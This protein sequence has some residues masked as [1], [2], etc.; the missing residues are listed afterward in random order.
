MFY[1]HFGLA[2]RSLKRNVL[3][4]SLMVAAIGVGIGASMTTLTLFRAMSADPIPDKSSRL[5]T[6]QID[7]WGK[8]K[9]QTAPDEPDK[10]PTQLTYTDAVGLM[11]AHPAFRQTAMYAIDLGLAPS[12]PRLQSFQVHARAVYRDFFA[13]FDVPF[14][15]GVAWPA[16]DDSAHSQVVVITRALNDRLFAGTNS[17]GQ[18][19]RL[20]NQSYRVVGVLDR[21]Q[22]LPRFYDL[23]DKHQ[24]GKTED[25]FLP[26]TRALESH[27]DS[28][29]GINC[30]G[31]SNLQSGWDGLLRSECVWL[32][33]WVEL[34]NSADALRYRQFLANYAAEQQRSGRFRWLPLT[35]LRDVRQWLAYSHVVTNEARLLVVVSFSFLLVCLLNAMGLMLAKIMGRARDIGVRRALGASRRTIVAQCLIEAAVV[36]IVGAFLGLALTLVGLWGLR[37]LLSERVAGLAHLDMTDITAAVVL[38][39]AAAVIA[40]LYPTWRASRVQPAWQLK[41]Q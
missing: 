33:F 8:V 16:G 19:L 40:G 28:A 24:F 15:Y 34:D 27:L 7:V 22:P 18:T 6:P 31:N 37:S 13:M 10:L 21:W 14:Q 26:L 41:A 5:F 32:Q 12:N 29:G 30:S 20:K 9:S 11:D 36:G 17:V 35:Q 3:L 25:V 2:V 39:L 23:E 4:T 38:A 1:Y